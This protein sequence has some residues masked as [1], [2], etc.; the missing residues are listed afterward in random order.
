M[1]KL[2][3]RLLPALLIAGSLVTLW[4]FAKM[5][6]TGILEKKDRTRLVFAAI[7]VIASTV[8]LLTVNISG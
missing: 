4:I 1:P 5:I 8:I 2:L 7:I 6:V 3:A